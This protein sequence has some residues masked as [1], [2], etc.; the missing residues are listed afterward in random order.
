MDGALQRRIDAVWA[1]RLG[2]D[3]TLLRAP[4]V[5]C[6]EARGEGARRVFLLGHDS[7]LLIHGEANAVRAI[8]AHLGGDASFPR[9]ATLR[10]ALGV[11]AGRA[12]GPAL[13]FHGESVPAILPGSG[14]ARLLR[15]ADRAALARLR[16]AVTQE[17]WEHCGLAQENELAAHAGVFVGEGLAAAAG[18]AVIGGSAARLG[19]LAHPGMRGRGAGRRA[20]ALAA[21]VAC[22]QGLLLLYQTLETNAASVRIARA[23]GLVSYARC[24]VIEEAVTTRC[25]GV[26]WSERRSA[27]RSPAC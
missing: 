22:E 20:A 15:S 1:Q 5:H 25:E 26:G 16:D 23:L 24:L 13:V 11:R 6:V 21:R 14:A 2:C 10:A 12:V 3:A 18:F 4:G 9:E 8:A 27:G 19:V 7:A 17:E